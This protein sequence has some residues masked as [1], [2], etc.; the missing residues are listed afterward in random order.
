MMISDFIKPYGKGEI[1]DMEVMFEW[2]GLWR[3]KDY[4]GMTVKIRFL[5]K[6]S[7]GYYDNKVVGSE[8]TVKTVPKRNW[9]SLNTSLQEIF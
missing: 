7:G 9:Q 8:Y 4:N 5:E 2:D 6:F 3:Q 1:A